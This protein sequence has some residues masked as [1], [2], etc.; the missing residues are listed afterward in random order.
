M[1]KTFKKYVEL[2]DI[3]FSLVF[4]VAAFGFGIILHDIIVHADIGNHEAEITVFPLGAVVAIV[5]L[6]LGLFFSGATSMCQRFD[7]VIGLGG[8]RKEFF[9]E[10][11]IFNGASSALC[12]VVYVALAG[13]EKMRLD[14]VWGQ[15]PLEFDIMPFLT[16]TNMAVVVIAIS[17]ASLFLAAIIMRFGKAGFW[18]IWA[19]YMIGCLA[20]SKTDDIVHSINPDFAQMVLKNATLIRIGIVLLAL[21][22][23]WIAWLIVRKH[24]VTG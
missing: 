13:L 2:K 9:L 11:A 14:R 24:H 18:V 23:A 12:V 6:F 10:R 4:V 15:Y 20:L 19:I 3:L 17:G 5:G 22:G 8:S 1:K 7:L 16:A 21:L